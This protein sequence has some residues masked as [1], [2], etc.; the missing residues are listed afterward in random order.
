MKTKQIIINYDQIALL[1]VPESWEQDRWH[2]QWNR[3][4]T[5]IEGDEDL[6]FLEYLQRFGIK[7]IPV[8]TWNEYD[9]AYK[10]LKVPF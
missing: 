3:H 6:T 5:S 9:M 2:K 7:V 1:E 8:E 4:L 10:D